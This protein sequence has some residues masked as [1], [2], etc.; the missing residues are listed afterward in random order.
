MTPGET[1]YPDR[2][3]SAGYDYQRLRMRTQARQT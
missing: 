2:Y 1:G 3:Q